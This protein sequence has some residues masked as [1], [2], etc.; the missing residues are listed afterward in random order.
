MAQYEKILVVKSEDLSYITR[1]HIEEKNQVLQVA[2]W[3][4][5]WCCGEHYIHTHTI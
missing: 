4:P 5:P 1:T 2:I 3:P